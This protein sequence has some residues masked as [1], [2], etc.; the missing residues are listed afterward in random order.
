MHQRGGEAASDVPFVGEEAP[1]FD[2]VNPLQW[3]SR[4][5]GILLPLQ[6]IEV[7]EL[8]YPW[9]IREMLGELRDVAAVNNDQIGRQFVKFLSDGGVQPGFIE[10]CHRERLSDEQRL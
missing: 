6:G 7:A 9:H 4:P 5:R 10:S 1:L 2:R 8:D 3:S